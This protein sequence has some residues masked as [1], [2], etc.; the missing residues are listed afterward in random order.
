[1]VVDGRC[2]EVVAVLEV[3]A[4]PEVDAALK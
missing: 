4:V 1:V 3:V 2:R